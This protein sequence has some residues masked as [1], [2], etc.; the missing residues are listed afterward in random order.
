MKAF[1]APSAMEI[2]DAKGA[3]EPH[4]SAGTGA[5][6]ADILDAALKGATKNAHGST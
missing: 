5:S 3:V 1:I 4:G 2:K 6:P